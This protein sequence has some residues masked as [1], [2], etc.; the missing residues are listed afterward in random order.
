VGLK[1][2]AENAEWAITARLMRMF[3]AIPKPLLWLA[4][5]IKP[6]S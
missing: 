4:D 1:D 3:R 2:N 6:G 5:F